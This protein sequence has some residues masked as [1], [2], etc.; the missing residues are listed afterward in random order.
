[1]KTLLC[2]LLIAIAGFGLAWR[3]KP[4]PAHKNTEVSKPQKRNC[5]LRLIAGLS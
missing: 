5:L 2:L 4:Y 1:M 3:D